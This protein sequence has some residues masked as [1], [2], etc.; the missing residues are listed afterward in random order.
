MLH[1]QR[2][3]LRD[4]LQHFNSIFNYSFNFVNYLPRSGRIDRDQAIWSQHNIQFK[5]W[6][7]ILVFLEQPPKVFFLLNFLR[8]IFLTDN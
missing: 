3:K 6:F 2:L 4:L 5:K 8:Q 7:R 1:D